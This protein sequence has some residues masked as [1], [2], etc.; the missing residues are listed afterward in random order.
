MPLKKANALLRMLVTR[1]G[2]NN[3]STAAKPTVARKGLKPRE[4]VLDE[5]AKPACHPVWGNPSLL[6]EPCAWPYSTRVRAAIAD[7]G[8][9]QDQDGLGGVCL[10]LL[11]QWADEDAQIGHVLDMGG[12]PDAGQ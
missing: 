1:Y 9:G 8:F 6:I 12:A 10:D 11:P 7:A 4:R 3:P 5:I 2:R